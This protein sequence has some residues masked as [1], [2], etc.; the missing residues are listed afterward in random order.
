MMEPMV[1]E[2]T[3]MVL[4]TPRHAPKIP[5]V[6]TCN[7]DWVTGKEIED[8]AYWA[9]QVRHSV[10]F[11]EAIEKIIAR[12]ETIFL[13]VGPGIGLGQLITQHPSKPAKIR[14]FPSLDPNAPA[15]NELG[16]M[17]SSLG[18]LWVAGVQ[19]EWDSFYAN[20]LRCRVPLP[21][22]PFE[23]K[24]HWVE[25]DTTAA[26]VPDASTQPTIARLQ[27]AGVSAIGQE[28][29]SDF[30]EQLIQEQLRLMARQ[31]EMLK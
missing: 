17:L 25:P 5:W 14:V 6:S 9:R 26:A 19:P 8:P 13:E 15:G 30:T 22:Y 1:S 31:L 7:G 18:R 21:T 27:T 23:R 2:F 4:R 12:P 20:E 28:G 3:E 24:R 10:R 11:V 16:T 29:S